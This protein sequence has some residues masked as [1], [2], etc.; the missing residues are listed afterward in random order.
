MKKMQKIII[1]AATVLFLSTPVYAKDTFEFC[2]KISNL[3]ETVMMKRQDGIS[4]KA[5]M[6]VVIKQGGPTD[7]MKSM[8]IDAYKQPR[9]HVAENAHRIVVDFKNT[10]Y[11]MC[12]KAMGEK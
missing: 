2:G 12:L 6:E 3:A 8:V 10:W 1:T 7:M 4:M 9:M 11:M 5:M